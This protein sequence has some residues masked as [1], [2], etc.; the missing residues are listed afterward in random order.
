VDVSSL[1]L[2]QNLVYGRM[3][4]LPLFSLLKYISKLDTL[5]AWNQNTGPYIHVL[6]FSKS[7]KSS[8]PSI[9]FSL[10]YMLKF[11][12]WAYM[13]C[14]SLTQIHTIVLHVRLLASFLYQ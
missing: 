13:F 9:M 7:S 6:S 10:A 1:T 12:D 8:I 5:V 2:P 4:S 14:A 11:I 3:F